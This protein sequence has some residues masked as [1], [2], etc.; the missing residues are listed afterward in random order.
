ME[1]DQKGENTTSKHKTSTGI[2]SIFSNS[3][4]VFQLLGELHVEGKCLA[5][6]WVLEFEIIRRAGAHSY[7]HKT[8]VRSKPL[9]L[10]AIEIYSLFIILIQLTN[11]VWLY[12]TPGNYKY[13]SLFQ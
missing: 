6:A 4:L 3:L 1:C 12:V 9:I 5:S 11:T 2:V 13:I 10:E 7:Q 8:S